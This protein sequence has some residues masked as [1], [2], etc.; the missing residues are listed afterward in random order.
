MSDERL[1]AL[2]D[3]IL[4]LAAKL[5]LRHPQLRDV[6]PLTGTE[7]AVIREVHR[8]PRSS[9]SQIADAT[10][11]QRSNASTAIRNLESRRLVVREHPASDARYVELVP[12]ELATEILGRIQSFWAERLRTV[13]DE[14]LSEAT[15]AAPLLERIAAALGA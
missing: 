9:P 13:P 15:S 1:A 12:T 8:H 11:L 7:I 4:E 6:V 2:A 14:L 10:G 5:D 3:V